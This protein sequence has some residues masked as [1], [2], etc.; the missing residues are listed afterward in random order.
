MQF[1]VKS[2][3]KTFIDLQDM[4]QRYYFKVRQ[5]TNFCERRKLPLLNNL[6]TKN[7]VQIFQLISTFLSTSN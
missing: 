1:L 3:K 4:I 5:I 7:Q 2:F 6:L